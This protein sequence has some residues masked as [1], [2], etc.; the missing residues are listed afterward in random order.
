LF[1]TN[2][3][4]IKRSGNL[5]S[6]GVISEIEN[7]DSI[8]SFKNDGSSLINRIRLNLT[9]KDES[10]TYNYRIF[11]SFSNPKYLSEPNN[12]SISFQIEG[13]DRDWV[14]IT[15]S[16]LEERIK[17]IKSKVPLRDKTISSTIT[18]SA[19][20]ISFLSFYILLNEMITSGREKINAVENRWNNKE[21]TDLGKLIIESQKVSI[22]DNPFTGSS[23]LIFILVLPFIMMFGLFPLIKL[24]YYFFPRYNFY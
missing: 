14:F 12:H 5:Y 13:D 4:Q 20:G 9:D 1:T 16:Q 24:F 3:N 7:I 2:K 21:I 15:T 6:N 11:M 8:F 19:L 22:I 17:R 23:S 10:Y 18:F